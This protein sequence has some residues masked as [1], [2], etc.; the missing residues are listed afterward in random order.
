MQPADCNALNSS[1]KSHEPDTGIQLQYH[2]KTSAYDTSELK[3]YTKLVSYKNLESAKPQPSYENVDKVFW[4]T[5]CRFKIQEEKNK[6]SELEFD[7]D[8]YIDMQLGELNCRPT[9][10]H[11][12]TCIKKYCSTS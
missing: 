1:F 8:N 3:P 5:R 12:T 6:E 4:P 9:H 7:I 11:Q 2:R 10:C